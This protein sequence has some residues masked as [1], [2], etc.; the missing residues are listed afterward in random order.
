MM[1]RLETPHGVLS[2]F[3][4]APQFLRMQLGVREDRLLGGNHVE[5]KANAHVYT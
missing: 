2:R 5:R 4:R 1:N 3:F